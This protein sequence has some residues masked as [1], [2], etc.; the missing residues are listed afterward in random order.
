T[1]DGYLSSA[2]LIE[3]S[4]GALYGTTEFGPT[5]A[6]VVFKL[7]K[8]GSGYRVLY[9]FGGNAVDG[10]NPRVGVIEGTDGVLYGT[11]PVGG[12]NSGG[13]VFKLNKDGSGYQTL[14]HF[15]VSA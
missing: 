6:G 7:N 12:T 14:Y 3:A 2:G 15:G 11:T 10:G 5:S 9:G 1:N 13:T 4:D 8:D